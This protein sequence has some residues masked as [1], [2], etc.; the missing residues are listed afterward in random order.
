MSNSSKPNAYLS[1]SHCDFD[2]ASQLKERLERVGIQIWMDST[3]IKGGQQ[4]VSAIMDGLKNAN[5][6]IV[7]WTERSSSSNWVEVEIDRAIID[8]V[9]AG[10]TRLI[11][12][13]GDRTDLPNVARHK[14]FI[15]FSRDYEAGFRQLCFAIGVSAAGV[16]SGACA[17]FV[18]RA[19]IRN[20]VERLLNDLREERIRIRDLC[21]I[22]IIRH[23]EDMPRTGKLIRFQKFNFD[24]PVRSIYDHLLSV[25]HTADHLLPILDHGISEDRKPDLA[26]AIAYHDLGEVLLGDV[27]SHT[28]ERDYPEAVIKIRASHQLLLPFRDHKERDRQ[29]NV[30]NAFVDLFLSR[31]HRQFAEKR[32]SVLRGRKNMRPLRDFFTLIDKIDPIIG[33]WRYIHL[34]RPLL[35]ARSNEFI[36]AMADFFDNP[37]VIAVASDYPDSRVNHLARALL[38]DDS[39]KQFFDNTEE[40]IA[41]VAKASRI[42]ESTLDS[43]LLTHLPRYVVPNRAPQ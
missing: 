43:L 2:S 4:F 14:H 25:A 37:D 41:A 42:P 18:V 11:I 33:V 1:Y 40:G 6:V 17:D 20:R 39:A 24:L 7:W 34:F 28:D 9:E 22:D 23:L 16:T 19:D 8:E 38:S 21:E 26:A 3:E 32:N 29:D 36:H 31:K 15:D 10:E 35:L 5:F 12:C 27:P 13:R 30:S